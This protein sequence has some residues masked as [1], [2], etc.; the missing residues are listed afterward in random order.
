M[1]GQTLTERRPPAAEPRNARCDRHV[2]NVGGLF[3]R[4]FVHIH[5]QDGAAELGY[6]LVQDSPLNGSKATKSALLESGEPDAFLTGPVRE[7]PLHGV[8]PPNAKSRIEMVRRLQE[9]KPSAADGCLASL[10]RDP[11]VR[12]LT[13]APEDREPEPSGTRCVG[14]ESEL[15]SAASPRAQLA[16]ASAPPCVRRSRHGPTGGVLRIDS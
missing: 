5:K 14:G 16:E 3:V 1:S 10:C 11:V 2:K 7:E 9:P 12:A 8:F 6:S 4:E 13:L 15:V